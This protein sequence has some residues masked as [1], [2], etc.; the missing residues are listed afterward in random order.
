MNTISIEHFTNENIQIVLGTDSLASN[1]MLSILYEMHTIRQNFPFL[2]VEKLLGWATINGARALQMDYII[3]S[4]EK[5]KK[6]GVVLCNEI[7]TNA[8]RVL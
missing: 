4:F 5:G 3:G 8:K 7:L 1:E 2:T 6:P